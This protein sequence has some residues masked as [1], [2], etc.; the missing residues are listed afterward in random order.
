MA[1]L[2]ADPILWTIAMSPI[3]ITMSDLL[4]M[5]VREIFVAEVLARAR[6]KADVRRAYS[7]LHDRMARG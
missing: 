7:A 3:P 6:H 1:A 5:P 2:D 4:V